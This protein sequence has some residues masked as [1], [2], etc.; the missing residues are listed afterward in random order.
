MNA[1]GPYRTTALLEVVFVHYWVAKNENYYKDVE[2]FNC[3]QVLLKSG[4][5]VNQLSRSLVNALKLHLAYCDHISEKL[6]K[7]LYAAEETIDSTTVENTSEE[8][9]TLRTLEVPSYLLRS[10][11][12][13][14]QFPKIR[15][16]EAIRQHF[17]NL[18]HHKNLFLR[19]PQLNL[20]FL[21]RDFLLF[22]VSL[23]EEYGNCYYC[24]SQ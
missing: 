15:C 11:F 4:A 24:E 6:A 18:D 1:T 21:L 9:L 7:L 22:F 10:P 2:I 20:P 3:V 8:N 13:D 12:E 14:R 19:I 16:R 17:L 23:N 5:T